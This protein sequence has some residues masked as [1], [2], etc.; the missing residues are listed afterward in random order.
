MMKSKA[1]SMLVV[2]LALAM[3]AR[4][5]AGASGLLLLM[6]RSRSLPRRSFTGSERPR[7]PS[8]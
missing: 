4:L 7:T 2:L 8:S 6:Q 3:A 1:K 5:Y